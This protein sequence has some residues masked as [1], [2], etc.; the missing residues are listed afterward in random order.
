MS[1][2]L[3]RGFALTALSLG[4]ALTARAEVFGYEWVL[5]SGP[6]NVIDSTA[7]CG[8]SG[9]YDKTGI[10]CRSTPGSICNLQIVPAGRCSY[11]AP[12]QHLCLAARRGSL[13]KRSE[14]RVSLRRLSGRSE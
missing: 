1:Q 12:G 9:C 14:H 2:T 10:L 7:S 3:S 4:L 6:N 13:C 11:G 8:F 5:Q